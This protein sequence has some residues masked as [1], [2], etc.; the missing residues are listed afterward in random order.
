MHADHL[1]P[2]RGP[3]MERVADDEPA[4]LYTATMATVD[5]LQ[6]A[7][8]AYTADRWE[9]ED[10]R[11]FGRD[12]GTSDMLNAHPRLYSSLSFGDPDYPDA[13]LSILGQLLAE[14]TEPNSGE[15]GRME[16]LADSMPELPEWITNNAPARTKRLFTTY[17][18]ERDA[19]EIPSVWKSVEESEESDVLPPLVDTADSD[20]LAN[21]PTQDQ[22]VLSEPLGFP[23]K[24]PFTQA[25]VADNARSIFIVHGHDISSMN[26][27]RTLVHRSTGVM[28]ISLAEEPGRGRTII[29]KFEEYGSTS[30]FVIVLLSPDDVGQTQV[31]S[32]LNVEP[33]PRA[34][35]NVILE[36]G[37]F[38]GKIGREN[39]VVMNG[40][41]EKPSDLAG[42]SY[43]AYPGDNWKYELHS[44]LAAVS[45]T[46]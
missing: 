19:S 7:A 15:A 38:I 46:P 5:P 29:E 39:I 27:I 31:D 40:G 1:A 13:T 44:E 36:L 37:Y 18:A 20:H 4:T 33:K 22:E 17:L 9:D 10:W 42:L 23:A 45:L 3:F 41:V 35:Q 16:L 21:G 26:S 32:E 14:A 11:Q 28:P 8:A 6:L 24:N 34:R 30:S 43:I 12:T 2:P 25:Q